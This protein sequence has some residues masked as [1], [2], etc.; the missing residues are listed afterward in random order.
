[1]S[2]DLRRVHPSLKVHY[3]TFNSSRILITS[4]QSFDYF[5]QFLPFANNPTSKSLCSVNS[6]ERRKVTVGLSRIIKN[7]P[8]YALKGFSRGFCPFFLVKVMKLLGC[9]ETAFGFFK[10]AFRDD[11]E[12]IV[13]RSC[14][15]AAHFFGRV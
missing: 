4:S 6:N 13:R 9:R 1:M 3:H 2:A 7:Q 14:C 5:T 10:L 8:G 15:I 12:G 11:S